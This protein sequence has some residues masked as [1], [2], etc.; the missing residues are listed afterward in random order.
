MTPSLKLTEADLDA[1]IDEWQRFHAERDGRQ[2]EQP[3]PE[4]STDADEPFGT[5]LVA[6][7]LAGLLMWTAFALAFLGLPQ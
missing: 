4:D 2:A 5:A 6:L 7:C 3:E 1:R